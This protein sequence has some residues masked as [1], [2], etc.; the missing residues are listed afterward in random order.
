M[1][2]NCSLTPAPYLRISR[3][4]IQA[5]Q[6]HVSNAQ[7]PGSQTHLASRSSRSHVWRVELCNPNRLPPCNTPHNLWVPTSAH[8][9]Y[10]YTDM[11]MYAGMYVCMYVRMYV[12]TY[13]RMYVC[14]YVCT[15]VRMYVGMYIC[16]YV[17]THTCRNICVY[18]YMYMYV[19]V[20]IYRYRHMQSPFKKLSA[21]P[22]CHQVAVY[23]VR[24]ADDADGGNALR[25]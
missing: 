24:D 13:V 22:F 9:L 5:R 1:L 3:H 11:C 12:C 14:M 18:I 17:H 15:Y 20:R 7:T 16:I 10:V 2:T 21:A 6:H 23:H 4:V 19:S 25:R 8:L